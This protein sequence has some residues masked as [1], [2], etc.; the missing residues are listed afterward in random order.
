MNLFSFGSTQICRGVNRYF[1]YKLCDKIPQ[2][3]KNEPRC[4]KIL[5]SGSRPRL[6]L[7]G[8]HRHKI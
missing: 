8:L 4:E 5:S 3:L 2:I 7:T 6:T 1:S